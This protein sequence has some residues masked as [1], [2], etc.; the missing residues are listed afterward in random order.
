MEV[1]PRY[2]LLT[3]LGKA[4]RKKWLFF[5]YFVQMRGWGGRALPKFFVTFSQT[6]YWVNLGIGRKGETPAQFFWHIGVQKK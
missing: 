6:V 5:F 3:L 4:S 2:K 1:A